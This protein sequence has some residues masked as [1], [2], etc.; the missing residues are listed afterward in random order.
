MKVVGVFPNQASVLR[1][2]D[3][4]LKEIDDDWRASRHYFQQESMQL[5][6]DWKSVPEKEK[7]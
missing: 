4:N 1:L 2:V 5:L 6:T 7:P 3:T